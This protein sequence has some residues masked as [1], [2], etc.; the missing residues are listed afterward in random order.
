MQAGEKVVCQDDRCGS[1]PIYTIGHSN[2]PADRF[3][4]LLRQ[5]QITL[6]A[7]V[8]SVPYSRYHPQ[9]NRESLASTLLLAA[10]T[11]SYLG[12]SLGGRATPSPKEGD[13]HPVDYELA[14]KEPKFRQ[15]IEWLMD[16]SLKARVV[17]M[18]AEREPLDCHRTL[19]VARELASRGVRICHI[20]SDGRLEPHEETEKRLLAA[21]GCQPDLFSLQCGPDELLRRAYQERSRSIT[22]STVER[23]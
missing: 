19:L 8:R 11:Y 17:I 14:S 3:V 15:G 18:C 21:T 10:V 6:L 5:H 2:Y 9:F 16:A 13:S 4:A 23:K 1:E 22:A 20:L 12:D 7:D